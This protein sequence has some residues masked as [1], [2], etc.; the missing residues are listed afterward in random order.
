M[1]HPPHEKGRRGKK[2]PQRILRTLVCFEKA[3]VNMEDPMIFMV[4]GF[5]ENGESWIKWKGAGNSLHDP[6][7]LLPSCFALYGKKNYL[8][9]Q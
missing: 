4:T 3:T 2:S 8:L 9:Q 1:A 7:H 5:W 6:Q